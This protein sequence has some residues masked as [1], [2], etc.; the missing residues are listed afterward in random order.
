M[1]LSAT[2]IK[3]PVGTTLL[4][5]AI[6]LAGALGYLVLP[7]SPLPQVESPYI[8]VSATLPGAD[9]GTMASAVA[10]P[11]ERQFGRIAGITEM[12]SQS[13]LGQ[14]SI[15]IGFDLNR[16][17]DGAARDVQAAIN[18][19][20]SNLPSNLPGLP[21]WRKV[22]PADA[23]IMIL[24][25]TSTM[26]SKGRMYDYAAS[27]LQQKLSQMD[28]VGLVNV[29]GGALPAVRIDL[30]VVALNQLGIGLEE[31]RTAV[32]QA[33]ANTPK[34][35][36]DG[37]TTS[38]TLATTDQLVKA[39][40]Y[41]P[42]IIAYRNGAA[43]RLGDVATVSD[44]VED[45]RTTGLVDSKPSILLIIYRQPG[46]N[47]IETVDRI[48]AAIGVLQAEIPA[49]IE[50]SVA[51][52]RTTTI[53]TSVRDVQITLLI[54]VFLVVLVV[55]AFLRDLRTT[56]IPSI[57]VPVSLIGTF[58]VMYLLGYSIDNLSLMALTIATG[59]VVDDA[60]VVLENVTRHLEKGATPFEAAMQGTKEIASTV[61]TMSVS[62]VSVFIPLLLMSGIIGRMFREFAVTLTVAVAIS[63]VVSLTTTPM[64]CATLLRPQQSY[65]RGRLYHASERVF[66]AV[67]GGYLASLRWVLR[68]PALMLIITILTVALT[69]RLS[70]II[71]KNLF[72]Q[73]DTGRLTG[74]II[75]DQNT[76][77]Q[78]MSTLIARFMKTVSEDPAVETSIA[79]SGGQN[80]GPPNNGR[81]FVTMKP[82]S[83]RK[84]GV[85]QVITR[86]R[87]K[88]SAIPGATLILQPVLDLRIGGRRSNAQ[89]Q[90]ILW[91]D[92][93]GELSSWSNTM[94]AKMRTLPGLADVN[95]DQMNG[96]LQTDLAIDRQTAERLGISAQDVDQTLYD[97]FGQRQIATMYM[98]LNQ[99][100]VVMEMEPRLWQEPS[101][102][103][104]L[105]VRS[106]DGT[107][108]P[109]SVFARHRA[110]TTALQVNH[111]G[112]FPSVTISFNL[113]PGFALGTAV[114]EITEA[115][116]ANGMPASIVPSFAGTAQAFQESLDNQVV[117]IAAAIATVYI[118]LGM[119]YE[120]FIHPITIIS[121]LPSAG[122]GA[123]LALI[124]FKTDLTII[125]FIGIILLIG[126]VKK[127]AILMIDFAL[128]VQR[129]EGRAAKEAIFEACQLR[130]RPIMMTTMSALFGGLPLAFGGGI[131]SELRQPLGIAIVGGLI[132]SQVLTLYTTP[133]IYLYLD[134]LRAVRPG[135]NQSPDAG[136]TAAAA[137]SAALPAPT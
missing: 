20:A 98:A 78:S 44:G 136:P 37:E 48:R 50:L 104:Y 89:Y 117:L 7:V 17:I 125:A 88:L 109:L 115:A 111:S 133:V 134:R 52:D 1:S 33:N 74:A 127:N 77:A 118:V 90:Y 18:A 38:W 137:A 93:L 27:I 11:L 66:E 19:A 40:E 51:L 86:L 128:D 83:E 68:H 8:Q 113:M 116:N 32:R 49:G 14:T 103:D 23:P 120:N 30:N 35:R 9:P 100:H 10:T 58:G 24:A 110:D 119:L 92:N 132:V 31:V 124:A 64:L 73:Q 2:F 13:F 57:A 69:V 59:F 81:F 28:G 53:R 84:L 131:G 126:I 4:T 41:R 82:L 70:M 55:F 62:L 95:T 106:S 12:S 75:A 54:S 47:I 42:L 101:G 108:V 39:A 43:V 99:Y 122:L 16:N 105:R 56:L 63:M 21:T 26:Y 46:A 65:R 91:G 97:A 61:V 94:L 85:D 112:Q 3:R 130:F 114:D 72:P 71:P 79:V 121:T 87:G 5:I 76:S 22:N 45:V 36:L 60:I 102:L 25:L 135:R 34:G 107:L 123:L 129:R 67:L 96:G 29:G 80:G 15:T 6:A